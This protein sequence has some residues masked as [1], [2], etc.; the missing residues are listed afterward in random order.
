MRLVWTITGTAKEGSNAH[1]CR[2]GPQH[3]GA[4]KIAYR[5][6]TLVLVRNDDGA[7]VRAEGNVHRPVPEM[8]RTLVANS[9]SKPVTIR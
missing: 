1:T 7:C 6:A 3:L 5:H 8:Q 9:T 4:F 2:N